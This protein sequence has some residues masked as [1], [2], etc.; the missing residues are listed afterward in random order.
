MH[1]FLDFLSD[2]INHQAFARSVWIMKSSIPG[3]RNETDVGSFP[4]VFELLTVVYFLG[5]TYIFLAFIMNGMLKGPYLRTSFVMKLSIVL[6]SLCLIATTI[7]SQLTMLVTS[8]TIHADP[9]SGKSNVLGRATQICTVTSKV[10][11]LVTCFGL[12]FTYVFR[13]L[14][15]YRFHSEFKSMNS[16][17][18]R[19][20]SSVAIEL[21]AVSLTVHL[22]MFGSSQTTTWY[23]GTGCTYIGFSDSLREFLLYAACFKV[24]ATYTLFGLFQWPVKIVTK[25]QVRL[26]TNNNALNVSSSLRDNRLSTDEHECRKLAKRSIKISTVSVIVCLLSDLVIILLENL[27]DDKSP[28]FY[29]TSFYDMSLFTRLVAMVL[30]Y[31]DWRDVLFG[32]FQKYC[33]A[34]AYEELD[35]EV[36]EVICLSTSVWVDF[37]SAL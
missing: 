33:F 5:A 31:D 29:V 7:T 17:T 30:V 4:I 2:D 20:I 28:C 14:H 23:P 8:G 19:V 16:T 34:N 36:E 13:W 25:D 24:L 37:R 11:A 18:I 21:I 27:L 9:T 26:Q 1:A 32:W 12:T 10:H 15:Q 35:E 22:Y 3:T 6:C